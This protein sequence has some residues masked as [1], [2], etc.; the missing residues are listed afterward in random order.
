M[1]KIHKDIKFLCTVFVANCTNIPNIYIYYSQKELKH[2]GL[3][4]LVTH[5][6]LEQNVL[7]I[8]RYIF[9]Y[10]YTKIRKEKN[11][12]RFRNY[13]KC[14]KDFNTLKLYTLKALLSKNWFFTSLLIF[15]HAKVPPY[16]GMPHYWH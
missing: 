4:I 11:S 5:G 16:I 13:I 7:N 6:I 8:F 15:W 12:Q 2:F 3:E 14:H 1:D 9:W 10:I